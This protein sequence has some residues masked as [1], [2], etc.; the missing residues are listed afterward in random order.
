MLERV[1]PRWLAIAAGVAFIVGV[2]GLYAGFMSLSPVLLLIAILLT[3]LAAI[4][5][6][7]PEAAVRAAAAARQ[8]GQTDPIAGAASASDQV[9]PAP[10]GVDAADRPA[11][12]HDES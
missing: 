4:L 1:Q 6:T 7:T 5:F 9:K 8:A 12:D 10:S 3:I 11:A 2:I